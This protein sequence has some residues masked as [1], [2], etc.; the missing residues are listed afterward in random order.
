MCGGGFRVQGL[1]V[2]CGGVWGLGT[3]EHHMALGV[4]HQHVDAHNSNSP[5]FTYS[6]SGY[7]G[8]IDR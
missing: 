6:T 3:Q 5:S 4:A 7:Q 2:G 8:L 1:A